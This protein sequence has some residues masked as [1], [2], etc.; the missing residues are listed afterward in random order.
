MFY[1]LILNIKIIY[2]LYIT[3]NNLFTQIP[4][5]YKHTTQWQSP[6]TKNQQPLLQPPPQQQ[7]LPQITTTI[8]RHSNKFQIQKS[9]QKR[10]KKNQNLQQNPNPIDQSMTKFNQPS[11]MRAMEDDAALDQ[12]A[13]DLRRG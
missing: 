8:T 5:I 9:Q 3:L 2:T 12:R 7:P 4:T 11:V 10:E 1:S 6:P 13:L